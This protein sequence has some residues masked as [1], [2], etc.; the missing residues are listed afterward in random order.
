MVGGHIGQQR[1]CVQRKMNSIAGPGMCQAQI[2]LRFGGYAL[3]C[4]TP[5]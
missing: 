1:M 3:A 2:Q 4:K 5:D